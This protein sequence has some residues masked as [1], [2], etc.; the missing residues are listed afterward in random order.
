MDYSGDNGISFS[1]EFMGNF[2]SAMSDNWSDA[3]AEL[4]LHLLCLKD[5]IKCTLLLAA[6]F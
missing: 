6:K 1:T 4:M 5:V 3:L 2:N